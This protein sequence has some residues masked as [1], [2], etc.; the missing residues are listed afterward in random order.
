VTTQAPALAAAPADAAPASAGAASTAAADA[1]AAGAGADAA[2][3]VLAGAGAAGGMVAGGV[4]AGGV[5]AGGVVEVPARVGARAVLGSAPVPVTD[6]AGRA[7]ARVGAAGRL[8]QFQMA[9]LAARTAPLLRRIDDADWFGLL[10]RA[11]ELVAAEL[12]DGSSAAVVGALSAST[13]L[14]VARARSGLQTVAGDLLRIEETLAAQAP[15]GAVS[16]FRTGTVPGRGWRWLPAGRTVY[17]RVPA[18]FPTIVIEWLQA[19]AARRPVLLGTSAADPF[20]SHLFAD[21]LYRC[22][23]PDGA[24]SVAHGDSAALC[25]LADQVLWP[26]AEP[27]A[28]VPPGALKTYHAGR[29]KAV[30]AGPDPGPAV[31]ARLGRMATHGCGRLCTNLSALAVGGDA[32]AAAEQLA[33]ELALPVL[34]LDADRA[35]VPAFPDRGQADALAR[36]IEAEVAAGAVDVTAAVTGTQLRV[37]LAGLAFLRPTVLLVDAESALWGRELPFPFVTVAKVPRSRL[38]AACAGSLIVAVPG[39]DPEL[40]EAL[41]QEPT[42]D[43]VFAGDQFD[44]GYHPTDP[45]EGYLADFLFAKKAVL[46]SAATP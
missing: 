20:T 35:L 4:V 30:L 2:G 28:G 19:L 18:N 9:E 36:L 29:S 46:T 15:D 39:E 1:D 38:R 12:A 27:P 17:V 23:L 24:L 33:A 5:V 40:V 25:R 11:A 8:V 21:A 45:H 26:G 10:R 41:A 44:R 22:G 31:W 6:G 32:R 13:G 37:E 34:P 16:A 42:V 7:V 3:G 43:K 14:P